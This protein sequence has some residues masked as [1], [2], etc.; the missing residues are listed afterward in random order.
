MSKYLILGAG[1]AGRRAAKAIRRKDASG[2]ITVVEEQASPFYARPMLGE[3]IGRGNGAGQVAT[4][5]K[6]WITDLGIKFQAGVKV[7]EVRLR[8]QKV[9]LSTNQVIP[10]DRLLISFGAKAQKLA[11]DDGSTSG[12]I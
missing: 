4:K 6:G 3:M 2:E 10:F 9:L 11:C 8:E 1:I 12:V 5:D 7:K